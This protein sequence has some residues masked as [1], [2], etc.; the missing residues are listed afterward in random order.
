MSRRC[1][2]W[3]ILGNVWILI[4]SIVLSLESHQVPAQW[5]SFRTFRQGIFT[6]HS[7][8]GEF[9]HQSFYLP[10]QPV[11]N[12]LWPT[13]VLNLMLNSIYILHGNGREVWT[14]E[15]PLCPHDQ[16]DAP[17]DTLSYKIS[18]TTIDLLHTY[19]YLLTCLLAVSRF[20]L[21]ISGA[22]NLS[23]IWQGDRSHTRSSGAKQTEH[24][25]SSVAWLGHKGSPPPPESSHRRASLID[26]IIDTGQ[27]SCPRRGS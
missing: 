27:I 6:V 21:T 8:G 15:C 12:C 7:A 20:S 3:L 19:T 10:C 16:P 9:P 24:P 17:S 26:L 23:S 11:G 25:N 13:S 5:L 18:C 4:S 22:I 1:C 2:H 14:P